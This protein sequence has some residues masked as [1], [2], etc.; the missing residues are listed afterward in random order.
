MDPRFAQLSEALQQHPGRQLHLPGLELRDSAVLA[1]FVVRGADARLLFTLRPAHFRRHAGQVSFPGGV[2][3]PEDPTTLHTALREL[4]EEL[5]VPE[6]AVQVLGMLD[7]IPT[8]SEF[9]VVPYV[10]LL[11]PSV[12][13]RPDA[14]EIAEL[15]EVPVS[16]S[17]CARA[18]PDRETLLPGSRARR[19]LLRRGPSH[20]LGRH[21]AHPLQPPGRDR[22]APGL[23]G[24][25][26]R[27]ML[28]PVVMAGG[29]GTRF[30][31][32]SRKARPKQF[33]PLATD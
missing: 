4:E 28:Y 10:G 1:P 14:G 13:L 33:L 3:D 27:M 11:D 30:W 17:A 21:R 2:R 7:E 19:V 32:L 15:L 31:P 9:R 25:K 20:H 5:G 24:N 29:S 26:A 8:T 12:E 16:D 23:G 18:P 6:R 22:Q